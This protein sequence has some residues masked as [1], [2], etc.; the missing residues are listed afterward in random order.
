[1]YGGMSGTVF[2]DQGDRLGATSEEMTSILAVTYFVNLISSPL[3][4]IVVD[5]T[6]DKEY[7]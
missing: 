3:T 4:G 5:I 7:I 1:M 6:H 2:I